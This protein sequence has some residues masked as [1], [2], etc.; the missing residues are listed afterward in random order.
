MKP[1]S[2]L[3]QKLA[4]QIKAVKLPEPQREFRFC[5]WRRYR[6][7]FAW[8]AQKLLVEC[9]GGVFSKG[10][11]WHLSVG[12][13]LDDLEKYNLAA[14]LGYRVLR[15]TAAEI[16]KGTALNQI[17]RALQG[18]IKEPEQWYLLSGD[19]A[20]MELRALGLGGKRGKL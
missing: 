3:E 8:P 14:L 13:Y 17:E 9:E 1:P 6:A 20:K 12:G 2:E 19:G 16:K 18:G 4:F 15:F 5:P 11:G 10:K 7:D